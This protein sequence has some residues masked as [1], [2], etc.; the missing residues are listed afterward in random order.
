M[1]TAQDKFPDVSTLEKPQSLPRRQSRFDDPFFAFQRI[2]SKFPEINYGSQSHSEPYTYPQMPLAVQ[3]LEVYRTVDVSEQFKRLNVQPMATGIKP[4]QQVQQLQPPSYNISTTD[5][6]RNQPKSLPSV[7]KHQM[8]QSGYTG[9]GQ[10]V[11]QPQLS[12]PLVN[13]LQDLP[14]R[15]DIQRVE[16]KPLN[17]SPLQTPARQLQPL[18]IPED[19]PNVYR[20]SSTDTLT[21]FAPPT[22]NIPPPPTSYPI[23]ASSKVGSTSTMDASITQINPRSSSKLAFASNTPKQLAPP[24]VPPKPVLTVADGNKATFSVSSLY[25][26]SIGV[27]GLKN[28]GNSCYLSSIIQC[29]S[30]TM[31]LARYFL[32]I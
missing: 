23:S 15:K 8:P 29:L 4:I 17:V 12:A 3:P 1:K 32:G 22:L 18:R 24:A 14:I 11:M 7:P 25:S 16:F 19:K 27:A 6:V 26:S 13:P 31:P 30:A 5:Y 28:L 20:S 9:S 2:S 21:K 10:Q